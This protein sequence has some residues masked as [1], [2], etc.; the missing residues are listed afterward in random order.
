MKI[1]LHIKNDSS[2]G[3]GRVVSVDYSLTGIDDFELDREDGVTGISG[4]D[5]WLGLSVSDAEAVLAQLEPLGLS[6]EFSVDAMVAL[7]SEIKIKKSI[8]SDFEESFVRF[9][10]ALKCMEK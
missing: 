1:K 5:F 4:L 10:E 2:D 8:L 6:D 7:R 3:A 9:K